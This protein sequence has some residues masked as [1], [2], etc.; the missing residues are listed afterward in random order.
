MP[1]TIAPTKANAIY[2]VT[3]L[4][5][6]TKVTGNLPWFTS[7]PALTRNVSI[8]SRARKSALLLYRDRAPQRTT[9]NV[10]K[11]S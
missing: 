1:S 4:S 10:V 7:L 2:A 3:M 9:G 8:G 5:L 6:L 11:E